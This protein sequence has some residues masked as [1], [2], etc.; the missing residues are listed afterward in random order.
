MVKFYI[1]SEVLRVM[2]RD[3]VISKLDEFKAYSIEQSSQYEMQYT[4][5]M[6][7]LYDAVDKY[8]GE[9]LPE[10]KKAVENYIF[11]LY[12]DIDLRSTE[13]EHPLSSSMASDPPKGYY[14]IYDCLYPFEW[15]ST[16]NEV[17]YAAFVMGQP[18]PK[19]STQTPQQPVSN[20]LVDTWTAELL[21]APKTD[22]SNI[23]KVSG[24]CSDNADSC[25]LE[26]LLTDQGN[27]IN[28]LNSDDIAKM[29]YVDRHVREFI[30][31]KRL[32]IYLPNNIL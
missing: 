16:K 1:K 14:D 2:T 32:Q 26:F 28:S 6:A 30:D 17:F 5:I 25:S 21:K 11:Q 24:W 4:S 29:I 31:E 8:Y 12:C 18:N 20:T 23:N 27:I 15:L 10:L 7:P 3:Q 22:I 9:S 19:E 13:Y